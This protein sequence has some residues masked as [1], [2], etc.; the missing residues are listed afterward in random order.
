[1]CV[2]VCVCVCVV[3]VVVVV[4]V[5][6]EWWVSVPGSRARSV[7]SV[8]VSARVPVGQF[9]HGTSVAASKK[10]FHS[11]SIGHDSRQHRPTRIS[12]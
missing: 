7:R 8:S 6:S 4:V 11:S 2:C 12:F 1:M 3:V 5:L 10:P 9:G